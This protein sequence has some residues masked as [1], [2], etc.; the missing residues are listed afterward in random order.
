MLYAPVPIIGKNQKWAWF[1][2]PLLVIVNELSKYSAFEFQTKPCHWQASCQIRGCPVNDKAGRSLGDEN[3][4]FFVKDRTLRNPQL[5]ISGIKLTGI[6][7]DRQKFFPGAV[8]RGT[9]FSYQGFGD[10]I[11]SPFVKDRP[12]QRWEPWLPP[13]LFYGLEMPPGLVLGIVHP[14]HFSAPFKPFVAFSASLAASSEQ[15]CQALLSPIS[16]H[17]FFLQHAAP[18]L[19]MI[20]ALSWLLLFFGIPR[21]GE[22]HFFVLSWEKIRR[23]ERVINTENYYIPDENHGCIPPDFAKLRKN[24]F[25]F[26]NLKE[27]RVSLQFP[28]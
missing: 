11:F 2:L 8:P 17:L 6:K 25:F 15:F 3:F 27:P 26:N 13:P 19:L 1:Y 5:G 14:I 16:S 21:G 20:C 23:G 4:V 7:N 10:G 22:L 28:S 9:L 24:L 12:G 18:A